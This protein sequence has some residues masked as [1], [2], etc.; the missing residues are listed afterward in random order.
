M[1]AR[2]IE[3]GFDFRE[4]ATPRDMSQVSADEAIRALFDAWEERE[5]AVVERQRA[6]LD[7]WERFKEAHGFPPGASAYAWPVDGP[8]GLIGGQNAPES[9]AETW[10]RHVPGYMGPNRTPMAVPHNSIG[11]VS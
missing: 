4:G 6:M 7:Q 11:G 3:H 10:T 2:V 9:R 8:H 1:R 5:R